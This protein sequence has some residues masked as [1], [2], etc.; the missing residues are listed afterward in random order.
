MRSPAGPSGAGR[1]MEVHCLRQN[2]SEQA[3]ARSH[4]S[5]FSPATMPRPPK[6]PP[7]EPDWEDVGASEPSTSSSS[8]APAPR[9][10]RSGTL[11][12]W[13]KSTPATSAAAPQTSPPP[14]PPSSSLFRAALRRL[15]DAGLALITATTSAVARLRCA[16]EPHL[17]APKHRLTALVTAALLALAATHVRTLRALKARDRDCRAL[18]GA[19]AALHRAVVTSSSSATGASAPL[20]PLLAAAGYTKDGLVGATGSEAASLAT[21]VLGKV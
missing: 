4:S 13:L 6:Q 7:T 15:Q 21:A 16:L 14:P 5:L 20:H 19:L 1:W 9:V 12:G 3:S 18:A 8:A 10:P 2:E 17:P 11:R